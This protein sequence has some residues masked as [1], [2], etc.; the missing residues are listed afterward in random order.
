MHMYNE[1]FKKY[2]MGYGSA[3]SVVLFLLALVIIGIYFRELRRLD[4]I[5]G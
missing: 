5:Y 3:I 4:E 2:M 1:S